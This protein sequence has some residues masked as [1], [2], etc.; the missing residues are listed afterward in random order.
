MAGLLRTPN[1]C[2][3]LCYTL[4][5]SGGSVTAVGQRIRRL[6]GGGRSCL[7]RQILSDYSTLIDNGTY[8][9][10]GLNV[11]AADHS[12]NTTNIDLIGLSQTGLEYTLYG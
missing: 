9:A 5:V 6:E 2:Y 1:F 3:I 8:T 7:F 10:V 4:C 11:L 12:L